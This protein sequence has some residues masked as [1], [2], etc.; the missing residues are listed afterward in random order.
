M[1][2][3]G[4]R[5]Q[6]LVCNMVMRLAFWRSASG[7][8]RD[9]RH[10]CRTRLK[11]EMLEDRCLLAAGPWTNPIDAND[12]NGDRSVT[13]S[14]ALVVINQI[15]RSSSSDLQDVVPPIL[16]ERSDQPS[17]HYDT[18]GDGLLTPLDALRV[19]NE[20][21]RQSQSRG[22]QATV[23]RSDVS[24][25]SLT[26]SPVTLSFTAGYALHAG[27][28]S[29]SNRDEVRFTAF[30]DRVSVNVETAAGDEPTVRVL[31]AAGNEVARGDQWAGRGEFQGFELAAVV[32]QEYTVVMERSEPSEAASDRGY[33]LEVYQYPVDRW[34]PST[35]S[36]ALPDRHG[37]TFESATDLALHSS[38][39][40]LTANLD[41]SD[42][43][44]FFRVPNA[45]PGSML[46]YGVQGLQIDLFDD[47]GDPLANGLAREDLVYVEAV[48]SDSVLV[49]VRSL[50]GDVGNYTMA[51]LLE[52]RVRVPN[53]F[54]PTFDPFQVWFDADSTFGSDLHGDTIQDATSLPSQTEVVVSHLD[55]AGDA[56]TFQLTTGFGSELT[57]SVQSEEVNDL[58]LRVT[59]ELGVAIQP[60]WQRRAGDAVGIGFYLDESRVVPGPLYLQVT[61]LS[62]SVGRYVLMRSERGL[63]DRPEPM[64]SLN[65]PKLTPDGRELPL[66]RYLP[67]TRDVI[68][69][70]AHGETMEQATPI[71]LTIPQS[72]WTSYLDGPGDRDAFQFVAPY[73]DIRTTLWRTGRLAESNAG[74]ITLL[75]SSGQAVD[76]NPVGDAS[77]Y[78]VR[79][80]SLQVGQQYTIVVSAGAASQFDRYALQLEPASDVGGHVDAGSVVELSFVDDSAA[81]DDRGLARGA[82]DFYRFS[83]S[84]S[85]AQVSVSGEVGFRTQIF[86]ASDGG[87]PVMSVSDERAEAVL[88]SVPDDTTATYY[89]AVWNP[90]HA[91]EYDL[92]VATFDLQNDRPID[93]DN[94]GTFERSESIEIGPQ[95]RSLRTSFD[96]RSDVDMYSFVAPFDRIAV[97]VHPGTALTGG[98][99]ASITLF[100]DQTGTVLPESQGGPLFS[101]SRWV[102]ESFVTI[103]GQTYFLRLENLGFDPLLAAILVIAYD[104]GEV[105]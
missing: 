103:P 15:N 93:D 14:D 77:L 96:S 46:V 5:N 97:I 74:E 33:R 36:I 30:Y 43:V 60:D 57:I 84:A 39:L 100:D 40:T 88:K 51:M 59:D 52:G 58:D 38:Y 24:P 17:A 65:A 66:I 70:D 8:R 80:A 49:R 11:C 48:D 94:D 91:S 98:Q 27:E 35:Q 19:I 85:R 47:E 10:K 13:P 63:Q 23:E 104:A 78:A 76:L 20:L 61:S 95:M 21:T 67:R 1:N 25:A 81:V 2:H 79:D 42:D 9:R 12:T 29:T 22:L 54:D 68:G 34:T 92:V 99:S 56:D 82:V 26:A 89:L 55:A 101:S 87:Q 16:G 75:D 64:P 105:D 6:S 37:D 83:T 41:D 53:D 4:W 28:F 73:S 72:Q 50:T 62:D 71:E 45:F 32:G 102:S 90:Q 69:I 18:S 44:D 31:D 7:G 3:A 86:A